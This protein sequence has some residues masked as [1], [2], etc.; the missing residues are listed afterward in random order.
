MSEYQYYE[1]QALDRPLGRR[2]QAELRAVST[3]ARI[4]AVSFTNHYE[5]GDLKADPIHLL[6][7]Y[8]DLFLYLA[9]WGSRRLALR[10]PK[11]LFEANELKRF[12]LDEQLAS[13]DV[14]GDSWIVDIYRDEVGLDDCYWDHDGIAWLGTIAPLRAAVVNGDLRLFYL[15]WLMAVEEGLVPD[16]T[17]EPLPGI[18]PLSASLQAFAEFFMIDNDLLE[19]AAQGPTQTAT[20]PTSAQAAAFIGSLD[21]E[22]KNALLLRLY[23]NDLAV[24]PELRRRC[25]RATASPPAGAQYRTAGQLRSAARRLAAERER[26]AAARTAAIRRRQE[27]EQA[28]AKAA[29]LATLAAQGDPPWQEVEDSAARR[30]AAGYERAT[31]LLLDLCEIARADGEAETFAR[32]LNAVIARH[33]K[34]VRFIERLH[35]AGLGGHARNDA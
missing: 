9:N 28:R 7:R 11:E 24:G 13:L 2:E 1:F 21:A 20:S 33:A 32:R 12:T 23:D 19:V 10:L 17:V 25:R 31:A 26:K 6:E 15:I 34:K 22:E 30:N 5:W 27:Q 29:R 18:A 14:A 4:T 35:S 16:D 3:R 8:F